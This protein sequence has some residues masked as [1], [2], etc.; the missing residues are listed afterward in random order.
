MP[1]E[2]QVIRQWISD[3]PERAK[4]LRRLVESGEIRAHDEDTKTN[5]NPLTMVC[6]QEDC[7]IT[8]SITR[9]C[10]CGNTIWLSPSTQEMLEARGNLPTTLMCPTCFFAM[11]LLPKC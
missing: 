8:G 10:E 1:S 4:Q 3:H 9:L 6:G 2:R 11:H 5:S 7:K